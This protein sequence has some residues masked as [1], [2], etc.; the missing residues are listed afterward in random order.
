[1]ITG[2]WPNKTKKY[3]V[4]NNN[5]YIEIT[6][7][8]ASSYNNVLTKMLTLHLNSTIVLLS[9]MGLAIGSTMLALLRKMICYLVLSF[10]LITFRL[11]I[12]VPYHLITVM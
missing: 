10:K 9:L 6:T 4:V 3:Y 7:G 2:A 8:Y 1:M 11:N 12:W 5:Y